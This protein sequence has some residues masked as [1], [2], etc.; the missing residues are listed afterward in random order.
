[1]K[2]L[3]QLLALVAVVLLS[4]LN[5]AGADIGDCHIECAYGGG[6]YHGPIAGGYWG[7]CNY[8]GELCGYYGTAYEEGGS[9]LED[10][11]CPSMGEM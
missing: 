9:P 7:C 11:Y 3:T 1:M 8:F 5:T 10:T 2:K 6:S 4:S